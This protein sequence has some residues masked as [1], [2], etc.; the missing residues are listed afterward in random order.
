MSDNVKVLIVDDDA[1]SRTVI[2][3]LLSE[4]GHDV[5]TAIDGTTALDKVQKENPNVVL[6]DIRLPGMDGYQTCRQ[7]KE[8]DG[9]APRVILYTACIDALNATKARE[10]AADDFLG[11]T[12]DFSNMREAIKRL[13]LKP[14]E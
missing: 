13:A 8:M 5:L 4:D 11:K 6:M 14:D 7:I 10:A 1:N 12:S 3:D 2:S 9:S